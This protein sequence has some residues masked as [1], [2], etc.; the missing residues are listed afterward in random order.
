LHNLGEGAA[1]NVSVL[2]NW[3]EDNFEIVE[4]SMEAT[5]EMIEA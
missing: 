5:F 3:P 1:Y 4:G 2:D